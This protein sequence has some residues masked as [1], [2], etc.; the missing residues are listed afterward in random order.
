[1]LPRLI[2][3]I[4]DQGYEVTLGDAFRDS[5][6]TYG[7]QGS[8]HRVRLAIDLN[9]FLEGTYLTATDDYAFAGAYWT[10]LH[11][12]HCWGGSDGKDGNHF[13]AFAPDFNM[14]Y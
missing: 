10:N 4:H 13:S 3:F 9:L 12:A 11:P 6:V 2:D 8:M 14:V 1:M 5:R 7:H